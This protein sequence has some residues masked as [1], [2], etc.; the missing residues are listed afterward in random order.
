[1]N[2]F[3]VS[4][5]NTINLCY[6]NTL[7]E[8]RLSLPH[9]IHKSHFPNHLNPIFSF[10]K[11]TVLITI[12]IIHISSHSSTYNSITYKHINVCTFKTIKK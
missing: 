4:P 6:S 1:M 11:N 8:L 12:P 7:V 9:S 2:L 10:L 3:R 5:P